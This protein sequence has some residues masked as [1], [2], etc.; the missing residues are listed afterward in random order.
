MAK[1]G[2]SA[3]DIIYLGKLE[4]G[5][6]TVLPVCLLTLLSISPDG[7]VWQVRGLESAEPFSHFIHYPDDDTDEDDPEPDHPLVSIAPRQ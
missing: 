4:N 7:E 1:K 5:K 2:Y 6:M 3:G